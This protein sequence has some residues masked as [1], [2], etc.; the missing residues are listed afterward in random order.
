MSVPS[1]V[2]AHASVVELTE[3]VRLSELRIHPVQDSLQCLSC[4][5]WA[6]PDRI[7]AVS[8]TDSLTCQPFSVSQQFAFFITIGIYVLTVTVKRRT[9]T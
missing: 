9:W 7:A 8:G 5:R 6:S 2:S 4:Q 1:C 3:D